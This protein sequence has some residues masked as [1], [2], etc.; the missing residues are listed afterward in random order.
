[1]PRTRWPRRA[2]NLALVVLAVVALEFVAVRL[3]PGAREAWGSAAS[4][5]PLLLVAAL[6]AELGSFACYSGL[7][8][9]VLPPAGRPRYGTLLA[10]DLTGN[11][12]SH[13]VPGGGAAAAAF[14]LGLLRRAGVSRADAVGVTALESAI[15]TLWLVGAFLAGLVLAVPSSGTHP[16]LRAA[17]LVAVILVMASA[18]A[19]AVLMAR[20]DLIIAST[21]ALAARVPLLPAEGL[22]RLV[23]GVIAQV[24]LV[25]GDRA[26]LRR[27]VTWGLGIWALDATCLLL[28][29]R[30]FGVT[31]SPGALV[32]TYALAGLLALVPLTPSGLGVVEG[33]AVPVLVSFGVPHAEALLGVLTWRLLEFWLPIPLALAAYLWLRLTHRLATEPHDGHEGREGREGPR[34]GQGGPGGGPDDEEGTTPAPERV[35]VPCAPAPPPT[36]ME[37]STP[38]VDEAERRDR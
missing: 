23:R 13:V 2:R 24:R 8:R 12:F 32:T 9:T 1:M 16:F 30:A 36:S 26:Q 29:V 6:A 14:R 34:D 4:A 33:V 17:A 22:E 35:Q 5:V 27:S 7:T 28:S 20:P 15:T 21:R 25:L 19:I 38:P 11:G 31:P 37:V 3:A 18:G 10:I